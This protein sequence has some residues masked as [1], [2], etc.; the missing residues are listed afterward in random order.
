MT[1]AIVP[2][3]LLARIAAVQD[4]ELQ[5][6]A[7]AARATLAVSREYGPGRSRLRLSIEDG[8]TLVAEAIP[9][10]DREISDAHN[11][12][13]LPG[14][15]VRGED[16]PATGDRAA[17]EAFDGLGATFDFYWDAFARNGI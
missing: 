14:T 8:D 12:E 9:A 1:P 5:E 6:A 11:R 13:T 2:P 10:P 7:E 4:P 16:D 3:Y 17:D 15:R